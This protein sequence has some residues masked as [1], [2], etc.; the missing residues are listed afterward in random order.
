[1]IQVILDF[2]LRNVDFGYFTVIRNPQSE[3]AGYLL[4]HEKQPIRAP[5]PERMA[6]NLCLHR[7]EPDRS[8]CKLLNGTDRF[9]H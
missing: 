8:H 9:R 2:G 6:E 7:S 3:Y 5:F 4:N 1:M